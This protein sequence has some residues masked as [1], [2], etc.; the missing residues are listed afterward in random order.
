MLNRPTRIQT[1]M[2]IAH[3]WAKRSTCM[4]RNV[5]AIIVRDRRIVSHGY[6]GVVSGAPHCGG[7]SCPGRTYC[8]LTIH[9]EINAITHIPETELVDPL[10]M[11]TTDSPCPYCA[12]RIVSDQWIRRVFFAVPYRLS[13]GMDLMKGRVE[14][15][16][17]MPA[18]YVMEYFTR[19]LV[20]PPT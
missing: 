19:E 14:V 20:E 16:H 3:A 1:Y 2:E 10:D 4:R 6:N 9:A 13:E 18:G 12:A 17:V 11:Y 5:G 8:D 7:N 15:Y